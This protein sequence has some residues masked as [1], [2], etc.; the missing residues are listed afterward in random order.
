[1]DPYSSSDLLKYKIANFMNNLVRSSPPGPS[2]GDPNKMAAIISTAQQEY[3]KNKDLEEKWVGGDTVV[4][5]RP[6][7]PY[8]DMIKG[9]D[10]W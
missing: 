10:L 5:E 4:W 7:L 1:V 6:A 8:L 3:N 9:P 2:G